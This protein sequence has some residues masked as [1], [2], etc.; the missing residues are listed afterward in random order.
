MP[1]DAAIPLLPPIVAQAREHL[2]RG[3]SEEAVRIA[4]GI[5]T[6]DWPSIC[7]QAKQGI[8]APADA[9]GVAGSGPAAKREDQSPIEPPVATEPPLGR[10][11]ATVP[12]APRDSVM[13]QG[14]ALRLI[15]L[16]EANLSLSA[17]HALPARGTRCPHALVRHY[18]CWLLR[19]HVP[20]ITV[21]EIGVLVNRNAMTVYGG[22]S[23][24]DYRLRRPRV[25]PMV[26]ALHR[27]VRKRIEGAVPCAA[28]DRLA[29]AQAGEGATP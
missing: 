12:A 29:R 11:A 2:T 9:V 23:Y 5:R 15:V 24:A 1:L 13:E 27:K 20:S 22:I 18:L 28:C 4:L 8:S 26:V 21:N 3:M 7:A 14:K 25:A 10:R 17:L 16:E 19:S 6:R